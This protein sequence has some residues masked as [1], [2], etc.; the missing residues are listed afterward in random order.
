M[1][2]DSLKLLNFRS[3]SSININFSP[4]LNI[5]FGM[6]GSGKT[7]IV[8][9]IY[10]LSLTKSF[11]TNNDNLMIM[12]NKNVSK[13]E[14]N[15]EKNNIKDNYQ[16][17]LQNHEKIVKINDKKVD[18]LSDYISNIFIILFNPEDLRII[19]ESPALRRKLLNIELSQLDNNYVLYL[20]G[21]N[22]ILKQ[23]NIYL[24]EMYINGTLSKNYLDVMTEKLVDYG[25]KI[26][27][28]RKKFI[29]KISLTIGSIYKDIFEYGDLSIKYKSDYNAKKEDI[30]KKYRENLKKDLFLG[31]TTFGIHHD[32]LDFILDDFL[33]KECGSEGQQ[34]NALISFKLAEI[35]II[36]SINKNYPILIFDDLSSELDKNKINNILNI[37]DEK[38][39]TFITTTNIDFF[40]SNVLKKAKLIKVNNSNLEEINYE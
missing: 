20:N 14:A 27:E 25:L 10:A 28:M 31:K 22:K 19:K 11:R 32:D 4:N 36:K 12:K 40:D 17:I 6:N 35:E 18:K 3:Y 8:E 34:K 24:K 16:L 23:R 13:V 1:K 38:V 2:I 9:S 26:F 39:Q 7:N 5:I 29:D 30:L 21:Y 15:I 33:L 37:L